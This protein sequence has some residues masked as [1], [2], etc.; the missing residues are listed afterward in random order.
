MQWRSVGKKRQVYLSYSPK[1]QQL[2][3]ELSEKTQ[4]GNLCKNLSKSQKCPKASS[5]NISLQHPN[6]DQQKT[7]KVAI[8]STVHT[9]CFFSCVFSTKTQFNRDNRE[10]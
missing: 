10:L 8:L 2:S 9:F 7:D 5:F 1:F 4:V 3:M 6:I